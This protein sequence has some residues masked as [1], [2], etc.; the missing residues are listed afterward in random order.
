MSE[1]PQMPAGAVVITPKQMYDAM[2]ETRDEVKRIALLMDPALNALRE[3]VKDVRDDA[4]VARS[5]V[6]K[7]AERV[8]V[9]ERWR[10]LLIGVAA[11]AGAG[12]QQLA[13]AVTGG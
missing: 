12:A 3:D 13:S 10:W 6:E 4:E 2:L 1:M 8:A 11:G 5:S 7:L 9:L